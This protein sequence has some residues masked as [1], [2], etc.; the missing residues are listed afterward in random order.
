MC[1]F[2][3]MQMGVLK[4]G[5]HFLFKKIMCPENRLVKDDTQ[6]EIVNIHGNKIQAGSII[7]QD[8]ND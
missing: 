7:N 2:E 1:K 8:L 5:A 6:F 3:N 4:Q